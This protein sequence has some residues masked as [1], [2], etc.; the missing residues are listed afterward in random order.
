MG[1][2]LWTGCGG[3]RFTR[4]AEALLSCGLVPGVA[5]Q[6]MHFNKTRGPREHDLML[7]PGESHTHPRL[8]PYS[9][10]CYVW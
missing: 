9:V 1:N 8:I 3:E 4:A 2:G 5:S 6:D 7:Q 10:L